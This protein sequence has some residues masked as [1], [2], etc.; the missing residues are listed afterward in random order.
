MT[1]AEFDKLTESRFDAVRLMRDT[2]GKEYA[3]NDQA[4]RL[5]NF[6]RSGQ[7]CGVTP[8]QAW[9]VL[10]DKHL[11]SI[12]NYVKSGGQTFSTE[13]IQSRITDAITYLLLLEGLIMDQRLESLT[14]VDPIEEICN[15]CSGA[16][17]YN[18]TNQMGVAHTV[19]CP[20]CQGKGKLYHSV[21][22]AN[23]ST[24]A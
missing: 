19:I 11:G 24:K 15:K 3:G 4:D 1:F 10:Y 18:E 21:G 20:K 22:V 17:A 9:F 14:K 8:I 13:N 6:K 23:A 5:A 2:K 16:G 12:E 7:R